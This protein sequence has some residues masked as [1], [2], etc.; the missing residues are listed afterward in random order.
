MGTRCCHNP[1]SSPGP[2]LFSLR[3]NNAESQ[4]YPFRMLRFSPSKNW[5]CILLTEKIE[6]HLLLVDEI[7]I[8]SV[9][10]I[11]ILSQIL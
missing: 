2:A 3:P 4:Y 11:E 9:N 7:D 5:F 10:E 8:R 6:R 1:L